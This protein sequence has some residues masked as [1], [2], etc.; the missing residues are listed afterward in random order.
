[1]NVQSMSLR[2]TT[3]FFLECDGG[4]VQ[5]DTGY[6]T[7]YGKYLNGLDTL[8]ITLSEINYLLLTH[9][10]DDHA[11]F[12]HQLLQDSGAQ[13]IVHRNALPFLE[14]GTV[15]EA[16]TY[17]NW[18]IRMLGTWFFLVHG[19]SYPPVHI[20]K[21]DRVIEGDSTLLREIGIEGQILYT[22]GHTRDSISVIVGE[23]A[24]VGDAAMNFFNFCRIKF[25][26]IIIQDMK[27]V[28]N[29][30]DRII[31]SGAKSIYPSHGDPFNVEKLIHTRMELITND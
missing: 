6:C 16:G 12:A 19:C 2:F 5:I 27:D 10:H 18:C 24:F 20:R 17:V 13:L 28:F 25:R 3:L 22:P 29:S 30:W 21:N 14:K 23:H 15:D 26:P 4:Y 8:D 11:G 1:M 31:E 7:E 9:H